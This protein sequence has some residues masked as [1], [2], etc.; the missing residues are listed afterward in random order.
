MFLPYIIVSPTVCILAVIYLYL[1]VRSIYLYILYIDPFLD[2][3]NR[4]LCFS[5]N[6]IIILNLVHFKCETRKDPSINVKS[7]RQKAKVS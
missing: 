2:W 4:F 1:I 6:S 5:C 7:D 3:S